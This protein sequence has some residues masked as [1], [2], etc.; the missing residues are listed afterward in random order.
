MHQDNGLPGYRKDCMLP[1]NFEMLVSSML[2]ISVYPFSSVVVV[3][4]VGEVGMSKAF[5]LYDLLPLLL[6]FT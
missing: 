3:H 6:D 2:E 1:V 4:N 5:L